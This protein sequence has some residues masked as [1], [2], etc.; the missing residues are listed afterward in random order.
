MTT[1]T[2]TYDCP[3]RNVCSDNGVECE[4]CDN[5]P[6]RSYY[7][8]IEPPYIPYIPWEPYYPWWLPPTIWW[9]TSGGNESHYQVRD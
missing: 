7:K 9:T 6:K 3:Y 8:P 2:V 1:T 5:N 4:T